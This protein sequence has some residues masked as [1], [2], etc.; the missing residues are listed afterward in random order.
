M[1]NKS[2]RDEFEVLYSDRVM[3][4]KR[5]ILM[6]LIAAITQATQDKTLSPDLWKLHIDATLDQLDESVY[7][8]TMRKLSE[9]EGDRARV[10]ELEKM[11]DNNFYATVKNED[12]HTEAAIIYTYHLMDRIIELKTKAAEGGEG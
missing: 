6:D 5:N 8:P 12:V 11:T 3:S 2:D 10:E 9:A 7:K 1:T 4:I